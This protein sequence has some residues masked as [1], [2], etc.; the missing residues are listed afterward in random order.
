LGDALLQISRIDDRP[1]AAHKL[2]AL[3]ELEVETEM[4]FDLKAGILQLILE[5]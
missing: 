2:V 5:F 3:A 1:V 4:L